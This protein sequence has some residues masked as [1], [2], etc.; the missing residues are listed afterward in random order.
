MMERQCHGLMHTLEDQENSR[1]VLLE[2]RIRS[3]K[4]Q[5]HQ[6]LLQLRFKDMDEIMMMEDSFMIKIKE[7]ENILD[8]QSERSTVLVTLV[9]N[10]LIKKKLVVAWNSE[11]EEDKIKDEK[12]EDEASGTTNNERVIVTKEEPVAPEVETTTSANEASPKA[13]K[14]DKG[15]KPMTEEDEKRLKLEAEEKLR[16]AKARENE[17]S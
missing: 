16:A 2:G 7:K 13:S 3:R 8:V 14:R 4:W 11:D 5:N 6:L 17:R 10:Y 1:R 12:R 9:V 15:K